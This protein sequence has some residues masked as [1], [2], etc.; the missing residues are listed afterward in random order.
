MAAP[1][2]IM[3]QLIPLQM[4]DPVAMTTDAVLPGEKRFVSQNRS[5]ESGS[6]L[7]QVEEASCANPLI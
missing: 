3:N 5:G 7:L 6:W 2:L 1:Q 4:M